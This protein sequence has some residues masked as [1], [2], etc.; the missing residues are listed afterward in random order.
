MESLKEGKRFLVKS[1]NRSEDKGGEGV[2]GYC[3]C[4]VPHSDEKYCSRSAVICKASN[5]PCYV[6]CV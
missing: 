2:G 4:T 3:V 5:F 6:C 1:E